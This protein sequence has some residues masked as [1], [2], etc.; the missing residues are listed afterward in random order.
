MPRLAPILRFAGFAL[1]VASA[2]LAAPESLSGLAQE[3]NNEALFDATTTRAELM[4]MGRAA[5]NL[6]HFTLAEIYYQ[7]VLLRSPEDVEAM[8]ELAALYRR[9]GRLEYARGL[10][11]RAGSLVPHRDDIPET[12]RQVEQE[13]RVSL[14]HQAD[15]LMAAAQF[16]A[17]LPRLSLLLSIDPDNARYHAAKARCL[18]AIGESDAALSSVDLALAKDPRE[19]YQRLREEISTQHEER[20]IA[21]LESSAK[22]LLESKEWMRDEAADVLQ[23]ILA[24]DPSNEWAREQFRALSGQPAAP[25]PVAPPPM[26]RQILDA[27]RDV[28]PGFARSLERHITAIVI[29]IAVVLVFRSPLARA[30]VKR[31]HDPSPLSGDLATIDVAEALRLVNASALTGTLVIRSPEGTARVY[32][33]SGDPVHCE[34][35]GREGLEAIVYLA[36]HV[37]EGTFAMKHGRIKDRRTIDQPLDLILAEGITTNKERDAAA[38]RN[39]ARREH[40]RKK[41]RMA[42]LL[43]TKSDKS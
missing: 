1:V 26:P 30:L 20:R 9:T 12:R 22:R 29:L 32:F 15:S 21:E 42:E 39:L 6:S 4:E 18:A 19:E 3:W 27:A 7:E 35:F 33:D 10:L 28:L 37:E 36:K 16:S 43:E 17:A 13:L 38:R 25:P 24:Q 34:A 8:C 41:S 11:M 2:P 5:V 23:A 40:G 31:A 14:A